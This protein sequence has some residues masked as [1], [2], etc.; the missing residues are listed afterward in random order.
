MVVS[1]LGVIPGRYKVTDMLLD[2][3]E[4]AF[5]SRP[6]DLGEMKNIHFEL[7]RDLGLPPALL[8]PLFC[9]FND[10]L[11]LVS[12]LPRAQGLDIIMG[13]GER[14][15]AAIMAE[16]LKAEGWDALAVTPE[17]IGLVSDDNFQDASILEDSLEE[18]VKRIFRAKQH[19][20]VP[21][22]VGVT[23]DGRPTTL[24]RGGSDYT[25]AVLGAGLKREA[26]MW[27]DV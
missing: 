20:V 15:S 21:G 6:A 18:M 19:L 8:D 4:E 2:G 9:Q 16:A 12:S 7:V 3:A 26:E 14:F 23:R 13:Y 5:E 1:L 17:E 11:S 27:T 24:G 10:H 25:A 22:Y